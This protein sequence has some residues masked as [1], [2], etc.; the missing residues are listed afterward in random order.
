METLMPAWIGFGSN[1][2]RGRE[3]LSAAWRCLGEF[4]GIR[5]VN[6]SHP[7]KSSPVDMVS[8]RWFT[9]AAGSLEVCLSPEELLDALKVVEADFGRL[10]AEEGVG[11]QDRPLDLDLLYYGVGGGHIVDSCDLVVPHPLISR[12]LFVLLPLTEIEPLLVDPKTRRT[13][14][15]MGKDLLNRETGQQLEVCDWKE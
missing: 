6:I 13:V 15:E 7:W 11:Y 2:G 12:R 5:T 10:R 1:I 4:P 9:N 3:Q 14:S 8:D